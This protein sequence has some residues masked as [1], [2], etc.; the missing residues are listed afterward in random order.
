[1]IYGRAGADDDGGHALHGG[2]GISQGL[3]R[4]S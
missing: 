1:L 2:V 3:E 4:L